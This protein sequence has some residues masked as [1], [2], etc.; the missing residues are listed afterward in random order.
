MTFL[1]LW[2]QTVVTEVI[3]LRHKEI[4]MDAG[5]EEDFRLDGESILPLKSHNGR[6][7]RMRVQDIVP[8]GLAQF[9]APGASPAFWTKKPSLREEVIEL[10][11]IDEYHRVDPIDMLKLKSPD[12][13]VQADTVWSIADRGADMADR[14]VLRTEWMRWEA[15]KGSLVINYPNAGS[16]TIDYGIPVGHFPTFGTPWTDT[17]ASDPIENLWALGAVALRDAGV[18]LPLYHMNSATYR[19]LRRNEQVKDSLSSY[20][21]NVFLPTDR[22]LKDLLREGTQ[23]RI[24]DSGYL[25]EGQTDYDLTKWIKDGQI[26]ATTSDYKYANRRIGEVLDGWCLVGVPGAEQPVARQGM[27]SEFIYD[28]KG[29]Q[30]VLRQ[31]SAR[32]VRLVSPNAIA[33]GRAY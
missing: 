30:T 1:D 5:G 15:L 3:K 8:T 2:D 16:I 25:T 17:R 13:N 33:W 7:A 20:G 11:D 9:K 24:V 14:N 18:Y 19:Y 32:I 26:M 23:W 21:R 6:Y 4:R 31:V 29:Q 10:H 28:R 27:Q 12:P 22:D